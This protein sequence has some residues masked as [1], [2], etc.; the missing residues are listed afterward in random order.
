[1]ED[2]RKAVFLGKQRAA[3]GCQVKQEWEEKG[4]PEAAQILNTIFGKSRNLTE[5][6]DEESVQRCNEIRQIR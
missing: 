3:S 5:K 6:S 2:E 4:F 1:M